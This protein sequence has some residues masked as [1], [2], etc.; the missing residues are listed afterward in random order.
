MSDM[1]KYCEILKNSKK[2]AVFGISHNS[3]RTSREIADY[4]KSNGYEVV[5]VNPAISKAGD[6]DVYPSLKDI[7][8]EIDIVDVFRRSEHIP[9]MIDDVLAAGPKVLWL[10][11][12]IRN[13]EAVK[14]AE[15]KGITVVQDECIAVIHSRCSNY[16]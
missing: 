15:E 4:L 6:I 8:F 14:S 12:G 1:K 7:P 16:R 5:G 3:N 2:V 13:N 11:L 9:D 10:Q